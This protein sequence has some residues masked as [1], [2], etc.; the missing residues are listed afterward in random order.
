MGIPRESVLHRNGF[1]LIELLVVVVVIG[2]LATIAIGGSRKAVEQTYTAVLKSDL[3]NLAVAE[4]NY[5]I[6][7]GQ[8]TRRRGQLEFSVS[9]DVI[10]RLRI[11]YGLG[12][13]ARVEHRKR[14][15]TRY[16]CA[17]FR[18]QIRPHAPAVEEGV[19]ACS[20]R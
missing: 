5:L 9:P 13:S 8:Y 17:L 11:N 6:E 7:N 3:R 10:L 14:R 19:I 4:E 1:T 20:E 18:G 12:W 16:F 2:I 15:P